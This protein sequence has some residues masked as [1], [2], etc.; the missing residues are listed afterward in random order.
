M[1]ILERVYFKFS[2]FICP[3]KRIKAIFLERDLKEN[4]EC[5]QLKNRIGF[6]KEPSK[7]FD[8]NEI[9]KR[10]FFA[11]RL[12]AQVKLNLIFGLIHNTIRIK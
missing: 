6:D 9:A 2:L 1:L 10:N 5:S 7:L 11:Q 4:S 8:P 3:S 12:K